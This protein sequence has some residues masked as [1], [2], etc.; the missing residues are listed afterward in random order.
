MNS[1]HVFPLSCRRRRSRPSSSPCA[2][3]QMQILLARSAQAA[4]RR[5]R[6][7]YVTSIKWRNQA[8]PAESGMRA[9]HIMHGSLVPEPA[10]WPPRLDHCRV[11]ESFRGVINMAQTKTQS[12][13]LFSTPSC[14]F[15]LF[16]PLRFSSNLAPPSQRAL[17]DCAG[18]GERERTERRSENGDV[19]RE[20]RQSRFLRGFSP[21]AYSTSID[22]MDEG[23]IST[24]RNWHGDA[25]TWMETRREGERGASLARSVALRGNRA[26]A[27]RRRR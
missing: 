14:T 21:L 22:G 25:N 16:H 23:N 24:T 26:A 7:T 12:S 6:L 3:E 18:G 13:P 11:L 8:T 9:G 10:P 5:G 2:S 20:R 15:S 4:G 19:S 1:L 27:R 17:L